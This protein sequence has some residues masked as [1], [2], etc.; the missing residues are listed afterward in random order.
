[1]LA[2][3]VFIAPLIGLLVCLWGG[4]ASAGWEHSDVAHPTCWWPLVYDLDEC[5]ESPN[6]E[7]RA[8]EGE[9]ALLLPT[10]ASPS[11]P[12]G[13][14]AFE[15]TRPTV[16][17]KSLA[18]NQF[19]QMLY[20][21]EDGIQ[22]RAIPVSTGVRMSYTPA[23]RGQVGRYVNTF[24]S[25]GSFIEHAWYLTRATGNIYIHGAPYT[26]SEGQKVYDGLEFLGV[27]PVSHG[28]IRVHPADAEWLAQWNPTGV[29]IVVT[30]PDFSKD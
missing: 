28:C 13:Q 22:I 8:R 19:A 26:L 5:D 14:A 1:M 30:A 24:Y 20:V 25:F 11:V 10:P 9:H 23:F 16:A 17:G 7:R 4:P 2:K 12:L 21:Y 15:V 27:K 3:R 6:I 29:P 18:V